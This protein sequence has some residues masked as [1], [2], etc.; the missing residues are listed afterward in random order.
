MQGAKHDSEIKSSISIMIF[1]QNK[2]EFHRWWFDSGRLFVLSVG[3]QKWCVTIVIW[4][5]SNTG[6]S[7]HT[8]RTSFY[9]WSNPLRFTSVWSCY[10]YMIDAKQHRLFFFSL[11][12][13]FSERK[14]CLMG[15]FHGKHSN[16]FWTGTN[17]DNDKVQLVCM[18]VCIWGDVLFTVELKQFDPSFKREQ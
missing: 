6:D 8:W 10:L 18:Y 4:I 16:L 12:L 3:T 2:S 1:R 13:Q 9:F 14:Q 17:D 5:S 15:F 11:F 7:S